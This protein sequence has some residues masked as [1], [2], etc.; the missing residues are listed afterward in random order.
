MIWVYKGMGFGKMY[1]ILSYEV[2]CLGSDYRFNTLFEFLYFLIVF[3]FFFYKC[4][5]VYDNNDL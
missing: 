1:G 3:S 5:I 4:V 2:I